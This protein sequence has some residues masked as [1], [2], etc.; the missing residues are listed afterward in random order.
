[1]PPQGWQV[2]AVCPST[3]KVFGAVQMFR[4]TTWQ[5]SWPMP[6]QMLHVPEEQLVPKDVPQLAP[7]A[8]QRETVPSN[9]QQ[10]PPAQVL[11]AQQGL[12]AMP[13]G[14]QMGGVAAVSQASVAAAQVLPAQHGS[15]VPPQ[16]TQPDGLEEVPPRQIVVVGSL[17][18][19][20][21]GELVG[22]QGVLTFPQPQAPC[23]HVP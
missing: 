23:M 20:E 14:L 10:P 1:M 22:Q 12:P 18:V 16:C 13:Q 4:L 19:H 6:P 11:F 17:Q 7:E 9:T 8:T 2:S 5:Q 15:F 21:V 3:Q